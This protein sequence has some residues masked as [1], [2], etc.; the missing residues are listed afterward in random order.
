MSRL[1]KF[2]SWLALQRKRA[3]LLATLRATNEL[4][5]NIRPGLGAD[6]PL[7]GYTIKLG[8]TDAAPGMAGLWLDEFLR[9]C[10]A[11]RIVDE[12]D[13]ISA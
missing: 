9:E 10:V 3:I 5:E 11:Q 7:D 6:A 1:T 13:L 8:G 4:L 2:D 12:D